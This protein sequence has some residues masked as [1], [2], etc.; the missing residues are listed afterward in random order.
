MMVT[1]PVG[2]GMQPAVLVA[3]PVIRGAPASWRAWAWPW[4]GSTRCPLATW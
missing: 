3:R 1:L 2:A 4:S